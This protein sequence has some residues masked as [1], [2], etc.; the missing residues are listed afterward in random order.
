MK[1]T[2]LFHLG[3]SGLA[4]ICAACGASS[5]SK[6]LLTARSAYAEA[7]NGEAA[8]LNPT[9]V[10]E[11]YKAL[12]SAEAAFED[13][14]GSAKERN[15]AYIATRKSELAVAEA[16]EAL[17]RQEQQRADETYQAALQQQAEE[18]S[19]YAEQ[20][21]QTQQQLQETQAAAAE[22]EKELRQMQALREERGRMVISLTG[23]L[24]ETGEAELSA[25][26]KSRLDLVA[27]ALSAYPDR[28]VV[29]E[30]YTDAQGD[31]EKNRAL[32]QLRA[33]AVR[34]YLQERG[35]PA[36]RLRAEG[37]GESNPIASN[38]TPTG[39]ANNRRVEIVLPLP[40]A[41][42][43]EPRTGA[44]PG[45]E[46]EP[47][48]QPVTGTDSDSADDPKP[49]AP[50]QHDQKTTATAATATAAASATATASAVR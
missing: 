17:A 12:Q 15:Y 24:F 39:R 44:A 29:I 33:N 30:G 47:L 10:H 36:E 31:E 41:Q 25:L 26:A 21:T 50:H 32:S 23:V 11:A 38:D 6:E 49:D 45:T 28:K 48:R 13:D 19:Q 9:G 16:S 5:P 7:R 18:G 1:T 20:L 40:G 14:A 3:V 37:K 22:A 42:E 4:L 43:E 2:R 8:R 46:E 35:V 34:E 27:N